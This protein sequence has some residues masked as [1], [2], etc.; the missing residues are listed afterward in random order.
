MKLED[1]LKGMEIEVEDV[2]SARY[3]LKTANDYHFAQIHLREQM[4][5]EL[6]RSEEE[7]DAQIL[8]ILQLF[9]TEKVWLDHYGNYEMRPIS[10]IP[11]P[12]PDEVPQW[13]KDAIAN[14]RSQLEIE[15][16]RAEAE[17]AENSEELLEMENYLEK[18]AGSWFKT[19]RGKGWL[20][21]QNK[22]TLGGC[23]MTNDGAEVEFEYREQDYD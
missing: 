4:E 7:T 1:P 22:V 9:L 6:R 13:A 20:A 11:N 12:L 16:E 18:K 14:L 15:R 3:A 17:L 8:K 23:T 10:Y 2:A 5:K 19:Q 21:G